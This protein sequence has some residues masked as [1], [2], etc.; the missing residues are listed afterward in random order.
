MTKPL[1]DT[2]LVIFAMEYLTK[3]AKVWALKTSIKECV[4]WFIYE[5]II[6]RFGIAF[7]MVSNCE[8]QVM[9]DI[10]WIFGYQTLN[11]HTL[12]A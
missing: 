10:C 7:E 2:C 11:H 6:I 12:Y 1:Y 5:R 9:S 3:F 8:F 4:V